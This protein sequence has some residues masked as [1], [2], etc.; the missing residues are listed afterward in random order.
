M[1]AYLLSSQSILDI[2]KRQN[3]PAESWL[4]AS[5]GRGI[6]EADICISC[7]T[8]MTILHS[9]QMNVSKARVA[10]DPKLIEYTHLLQN[11]QILLAKFDQDDR[12]VPMD[13]LVATLWGDL[14]DLRITYANP[15]GEPYDIT[16]AE[17]VELATAAVGRNGHG[18]IYVDKHQA[19]H[20]LVHTLA[21][22]CPE[23][24]IVNL[25]NP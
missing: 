8:P 17:K 23:A 25:R 21:V 11:A 22:E 7:V 4:E 13:S 9:I 15:A 10:K 2:A 14:L 18:F 6:F 3:L 1:S 20:S 16:S 5:A 24:L 19:A 12:I